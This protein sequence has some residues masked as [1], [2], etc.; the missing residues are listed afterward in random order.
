M[1]FETAYEQAQDELRELGETRPR[2]CFDGSQCALVD[3]TCDECAWRR[4]IDEEA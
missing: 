2:R 3:T 4:N 1:D